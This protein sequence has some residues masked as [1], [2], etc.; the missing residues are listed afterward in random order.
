MTEQELQQLVE[1]LSLQYFGR[2][3]RHRV[4][5][6][7][8]MTTTGGRYHLTDHHLEINA[9]FLAPQYHEELLGIIKHELVHYHLHLA[10]RGFRHRDADFKLLLRHVGGLR[11][12]PDIGLR[13]QQKAKY[14][15]VCRKCGQK[16]FRVRK[17][18]VHRYSCGK[19]GA[20]LSLI[21]K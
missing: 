8:R 9:H 15:Y 4:K 19:C 10:G 5:I 20:Q 21:K 11:Y 6:N 16:Y 13:H 14:V 18:N 1:K 2:R 17:I 3:F 12:A 7:R